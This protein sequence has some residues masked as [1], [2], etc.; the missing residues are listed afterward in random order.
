M[1]YY[2]QGPKEPPRKP[3]L[4]EQ[5][6]FRL[7]LLCGLFSF[8]RAR[9]GIWTICWRYRSSTFNTRLP[10]LILTLSGNATRR[11]RNLK[12]NKPSSYFPTNFL[13]CP[14]RMAFHIVIHISRRAETRRSFGTSIEIGASHIL[15]MY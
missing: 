3:P 5:P 9:C 11:R 8:C 10:P 14:M 7:I 15:Y 6:L 12:R 13:P 4:K 1:P 2:P